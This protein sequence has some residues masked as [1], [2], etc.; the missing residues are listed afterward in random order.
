MK[1]STAQVSV[2]D[3]PPLSKKS[4]PPS[5]NQPESMQNE[6]AALAH[7]LQKDNLKTIKDKKKLGEKTADPRFQPLI[8]F[9]FKKFEQL[10]GHKFVAHDADF[11]EL[12]RLLQRTRADPQF[13][14][15]S[16]K[17]AMLRF[18]SSADPFHLKQGKPLC[19]WAGNINAFMARAAPAQQP[20]DDGGRALRANYASQLR[21]KS[22]PNP[23]EVRWLECY[24]A[25]YMDEE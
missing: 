20:A 1:K 24:D 14:L 13:E 9:F 15:E 23:N 16:M 7:E 6:V 10:R 17:A 21:A 4:T 25:G 18:L 12:K 19:Y 8:D 11:K 22:N 3:T 5:E 2:L